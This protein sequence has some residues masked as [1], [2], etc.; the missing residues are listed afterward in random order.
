MQKIRTTISTSANYLTGFSL[1]EVLVAL[2]LISILGTTLF[3]WLNTN[4]INI[5]RINHANRQVMHKD[6][7]LEYVSLINP[8]QTPQ[9]EEAIGA[10]RIHWESAIVNPV[11]Q[12]RFVTGFISKS[13]IGV[14]QITLQLIENETGEEVTQIEL[15]QTGFY[16][17]K[18]QFN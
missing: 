1:L 16:G 18:Y 3:S 11:S 17:Q 7:L 2:V 6:L 4:L 12:G 14:Y 8:M 10:Y 9:G 13:K 5:N 15:L